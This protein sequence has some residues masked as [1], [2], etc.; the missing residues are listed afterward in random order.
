MTKVTL[1]G[2]LPASIVSTAYQ[3]RVVF[4]DALNNQV[5]Q[6]LVN[7]LGADF[8]APT[9]TFTGPGANSF[10][11]STGAV[12]AY[13]VTATDN[14]S[15][16]GASPLTVS[17]L[18][19]SPAGTQCVFGTSTTALP[20][21]NSAS[22]TLTFFETTGATLAS[23]TAGEGYY[24]VTIML[25]DQAGNVTTLV[26]NQVSLVDAT[27]PGF[28]GG[29]SL[30]NIYNGGQP[31]VFTAT[32][33]D[34]IDLSSI[35]G[36]LSYPGTGTNIRF[37][38]QTLGTYGPAAFTTTSLVNYTIPQFI[39]CLNA[40]NDFT[41]T[42]NQPNQFQFT[43]SDFAGNAT[44]LAQGIPSVNVQACGAVGDVAINFFNS[45]APDFGTGKTQVSL[46]GTTSS[47][48]SA[49]VTLSAVAD[50]PLNTSL[51][52]FARVDFYWLDGNGNQRL[53]G[54]AS[55]ALTQTQTNRTWTY[56]FVWDPNSPV[57][58][59]ANVTIV[60]IGVDSN[61]DAVLTNTQTVVTVP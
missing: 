41:T 40:Q 37:P 53:I 39:R 9:G 22:Q 61:G 21:V 25:T 38:A 30:M 54:T 14:A 42:T 33:K 17:V 19:Q 58:A 52:P 43:V 56:T 7:T 32:A 55:P 8:V 49:T 18:L 51:N 1:G 46:A 36:V 59:P 15:G 57:P 24:T 16:F 10:F 5:C 35:F 47:T 60:A 13:A 31:A 50:V 48:T 6:D 45:N 34:N 27:A 2:Q 44:Q 11:T 20:C 12:P 26:T 29:I 23:P 4:T 3:V 28:T